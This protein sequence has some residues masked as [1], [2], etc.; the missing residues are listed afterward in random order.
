MSEDEN[1]ATPIPTPTYRTVL[2]NCLLD[3][4]R[5]QNAESLEGQWVTTMTLHRHSPLE[6]KKDVKELYDKIQAELEPIGRIKG[7]DFHTTYTVRMKLK[8]RLMIKYG[9]QFH[10]AI[11]DS[12]H[13]H[14]WTRDTWH[15][16]TSQDFKGMPGESENESIEGGE[17]EE[18]G[19]TE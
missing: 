13:K 3:C 7:H 2:M 6:V 4:V 10:D 18:G 17:G 16:L 19:E 9:L 1:K 5:A 15:P 11:M 14:G 12:L 8:D